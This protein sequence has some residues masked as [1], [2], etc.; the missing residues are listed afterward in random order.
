MTMR[1]ELLNPASGPRSI[2]WPNRF[3]ALA[4]DRIGQWRTAWRRRRS[5]H[6]VAALPRHILHDIGWPAA[7]DPRQCGESE[8][9]IGLKQRRK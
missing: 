7:D 5:Q 1:Y 9:R 8:I 6:A 3:Y 4:R 2:L